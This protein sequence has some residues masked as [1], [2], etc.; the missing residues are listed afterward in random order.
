MQSLVKFFLDQIYCMQI[1][2]VELQNIISRYRVYYI[3]IAIVD[4]FGI[5]RCDFTK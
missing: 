4:K 1:Q 3:R 5:D 2:A